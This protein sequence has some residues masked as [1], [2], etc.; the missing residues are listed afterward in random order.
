MHTYL[1]YSSS[2][3]VWAVQEVAVAQ[4]VTVMWGTKTLPWIYFDVLIDAYVSY[5]LGQTIHI[6]LFPA[7][8]FFWDAASA[9]QTARSRYQGSHQD[10]GLAA[11]LIRFRGF[12]STDPRDKVYGLLRLSR[13]SASITPDYTHTEA[14]VFKETVRLSIAQSRGLAI[15]S[16]VNYLDRSL[17]LPSWCPNWSCSAADNRP[18]FSREFRSAGE[19]EAAAQFN[20]EILTLRGI[21]V[22]KIAQL[23]IF[24]NENV[25][26]DKAEL[27]A[28]QAVVRSRD[29][30]DSP[31]ETE[32]ARQVVLRAILDINSLNYFDRMLTNLHQQQWYEQGAREE[33]VEQVYVEN[34]IQRMLEDP[35]FVNR[36]T[37]L[38]SSKGEMPLINAKGRNL[39]VSDKGYLGLVPTSVREGDAL[40]VFFGGRVVFCIRPV[41]GQETFELIGDW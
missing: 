24:P 41:E 7:T 1:T 26:L 21:K 32:E 17:L 30:Q 11:L 38:N 18:F 36:R 28:L 12:E 15:L 27:E 9:I 33:K 20:G 22:D 34:Y 5:F 31:Y 2:R 40:V 8:Y 3:R 39:F 13:E 10:H 35:F 4:T 25:A 29:A 6:P 37:W 16:A 14:E 23:H 19:S